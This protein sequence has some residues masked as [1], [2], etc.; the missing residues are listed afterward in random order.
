MID[1]AGRTALRLPRTQSEGRHAEPP[2]PALHL[3]RRP[4][5]AWFFASI[6][7]TVLAHT[8]LYAFFSL[9][10]DALGY[11]K[12][13]VGALLL[14]QALATF[15]ALMMPGAAVALGLLPVEA[16]EGFRWALLGAATVLGGG[17]G[18]LSQLL[19]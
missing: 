1:A 13:A 10:L 17:A 9:H 5:L 7:F 19:K 4:A 15:M 11:G 8:S 14:V 3:L 6:F 16:L 12:Q 2:P 18:A